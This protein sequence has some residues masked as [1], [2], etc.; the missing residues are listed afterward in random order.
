MQL[1]ASIL[2]LF[3]FESQPF[4]PSPKSL[5]CNFKKSPRKTSLFY[6]YQTRFCPQK[7]SIW[8]RNITNLGGQTIQQLELLWPILSYCFLGLIS[9][10]WLDPGVGNYL[11]A[12]FNIWEIN[13]MTPLHQGN[14]WR[15]W[16]T[17]QLAEL[18]M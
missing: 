8:N 10:R 5:Y 4:Q 12:F 2:L 17:C 13:Y 9:N 18:P 14:E 6:L 16:L 3:S 15:R 1:T 11:T 7:Q